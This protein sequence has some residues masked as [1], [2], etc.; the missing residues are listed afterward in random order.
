MASEEVELEVSGESKVS[1]EQ[2]E[3]EEPEVA[4]GRKMPES[5]RS[6]PAPRLI[7]EAGGRAQ[8]F[9]RLK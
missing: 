3:A 8:M 7:H 5:K 2:E 6:A 1:G 4:R 9:P